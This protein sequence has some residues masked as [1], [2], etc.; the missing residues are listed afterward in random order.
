MEIRLDQQLFLVRLLVDALALLYPQF[1]FLILSFLPLALPL[2]ELE[3]AQLRAQ[4]LELLGLLV[5]VE[6]V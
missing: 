6:E 5:L 3:L 4:V 2:G 1:P